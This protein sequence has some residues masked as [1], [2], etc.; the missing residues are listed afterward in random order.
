MIGSAGFEEVIGKVRGR[1]IQKHGWAKKRGIG[2][3]EEGVRMLVVQARQSLVNDWDS[4]GRNVME[5]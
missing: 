3:L 1:R 5:S 2:R 4:D